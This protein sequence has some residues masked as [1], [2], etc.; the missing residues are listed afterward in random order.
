MVEADNHNNIDYVAQ[1]DNL[2]TSGIKA[3]M[4]ALKIKHG[5]TTNQVLICSSC[6]RDL[7]ITVYHGNSLCNSCFQAFRS[8]YE[9]A[10]KYDNDKGIMGPSNK[11]KEALKQ[12]QEAADMMTQLDDDQRLIFSRFKRLMVN[13]GIHGTMFNA[14]VIGAGHEDNKPFVTIKVNLIPVTGTL[15]QFGQK[16]LNLMKDHKLKLISIQSPDNADYFYITLQAL[17]ND[18][19]QPLGTAPLS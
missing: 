13:S 9:E 17:D 15:A 11:D 2:R 16:Q 12:K 19:V 7:A 18:K 6:G 5:P 10:L 1:Q 14:A 8:S 3:T 4:D